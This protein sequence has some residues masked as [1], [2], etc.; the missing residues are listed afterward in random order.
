MTTKDCVLLAEDA[1]AEVDLLRWAFRKA[2]YM[3]S[4]FDHSGPQDDRH[5]LVSSRILEQDVS[6]EDASLQIEYNWADG[7]TT[8]GPMRFVRMGNDWRQA[9][10]FDPPALGKMSSGLQTEGAALA[11][12]PVSK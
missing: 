7:S 3:L 4:L 10:N 8:A 11:N 6:G 9:L 5:T 1:R 12:Q 2:G